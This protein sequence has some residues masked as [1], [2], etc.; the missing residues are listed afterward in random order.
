MNGK[1]D[2]FGHTAIILFFSGNPDKNIIDSNG[3]KLLWNYEKIIMINKLIE[4]MCS[5]PELR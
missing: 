3:F 2:N 5:K 1:I 4:V